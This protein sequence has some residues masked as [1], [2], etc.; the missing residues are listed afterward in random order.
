MKSRSFGGERPPAPFVP[1][2]DVHAVVVAP[3]GEALLLE[4]GWGEGGLKEQR[5]LLLFFWN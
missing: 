4:V 1:R 2:P 3:A 5:V